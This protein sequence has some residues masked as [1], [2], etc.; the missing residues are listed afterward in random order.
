MIDASVVHYFH[1]PAQVAFYDIEND[2]Y[3]GGI[4]FGKV[5]IC[6]ECGTAIDIEDYL[7]DVE[8]MC[9]AVNFPII[10]LT[11]CNISAEMLGDT[12]FNSFTGEI[13]TD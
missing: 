8:E 5:I 10:P 13:I 12:M 6:L 7:S 9:P 2:V 11:W 3:I 4:G 1:T